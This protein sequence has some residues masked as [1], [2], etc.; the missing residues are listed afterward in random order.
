MSFPLKISRDPNYS[1]PA[2]T[3]HR[4]QQR[5][6][7]VFERAGNLTRAQA[8]EVVWHRIYQRVRE[9]TRP[10]CRVTSAQ[11]A[12]RNRVAGSGKTDKRRGLGLCGGCREHAGLKIG[13]C[14]RDCQRRDWLRHREYCCGY[15]EGPREYPF[16]PEA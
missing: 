16:D 10:G 4:V 11:A 8:F 12:L 14:S 6:C 7:T 9:C 13:Y 5:A 2:Y 15:A 1:H 3:K